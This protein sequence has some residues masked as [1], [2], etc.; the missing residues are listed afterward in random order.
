VGWVKSGADTGAIFGACP[1]SGSGRDHSRS[2]GSLQG[3]DLAFDPLGQG[4]FCCFKV[5]SRLQVY[6]TLGVGAEKA[7]QAQGPIGRDG[8]LAGTN[9]VDSALGYT[10]RLG[11]SIAG[12]LHRDE[13]ILKKDFTGVYGGKVAFV[14][15]KNSFRGNW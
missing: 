6:L 9:F 1:Q 12:D 7:C 4:D 11:Q 3:V 8:T 14:Q 15:N 2:G 5:I 13:K 10:D